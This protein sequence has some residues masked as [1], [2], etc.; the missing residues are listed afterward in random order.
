LLS[1]D[2]PGGPQWWVKDT[3]RGAVQANEKGIENASACLAQAAGWGRPVTKGEFLS[4]FE[5]YGF[6]TDEIVPFLAQHGIDLEALPVSLENGATVAESW[7]EWKRIMGML[8]Y[9]S[10]IEAAFAFAGIDPKARGPLSDHDQAKLSHWE[11]V[12]ERAIHSGELVAEKAESLTMRG[13]R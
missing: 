8:A 4:D 10:H 11:I 6:I 2:G 12:V 7:P 5:R 1:T 13:E 3:L 9:L